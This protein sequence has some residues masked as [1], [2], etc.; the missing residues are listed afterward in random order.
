[1]LHAAGYD[2]SV[3]TNLSI[4]ERREFFEM[5]TSTP[6]AGTAV[7]VVSF[8]IDNYEI[9]QLALADVTIIGINYGRS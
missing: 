6:N 1:M 8:D 9:T 2:I 3:F 7:I 4:E 5:L